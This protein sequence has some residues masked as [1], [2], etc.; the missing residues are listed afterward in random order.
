[1]LSSNEDERACPGAPGGLVTA[2]A[3]DIA[4]GLF[5]GRNSG[6]PVAYCGS[7]LAAIAGTAQFSDALSGLQGLTFATDGFTFGGTNNALGLNG[8]TAANTVADAATIEDAV[9]A[10]SPSLIG[11]FAATTPSMNTSRYDTTATLLANGIVLIAGGA[12]F[13]STTFE[14]TFL[15]STE[16]YNPATNSF[17]ASTPVMTTAR[18]GATATLLPNGKVL[19]ASGSAAGFLTSAELYDPVANSF[20]ATTNSMNIGRYFATATLLPNGKVLIA[21]GYGNAGVL[22]STE[23]YDPVS[24]TFATTTPSTSAGR[25]FATATLLPNGKVLIAGGYDASF[26]AQNT[27]DL[28]DPASNSFAASTPSMNSAR[29]QATATLLP[30]GKV[31]IAGGG[32]ALNS[33]E[34]Y[35]PVSNSFAASTPVMNVGRNLAV[36]A[37][38]PSGKVLIAGGGDG[39]ANTELYDPASNTFSASPPVMN[40]GRYETTATLL[41]SGE[42]L[43]AGGFTF[44]TSTSL[45]S[46]ELYNPRATPTPTP[47]A[48]PSPSPAPTPSPSPTP[49]ASAS[50]SPSPTASPSPSPTPTPLAALAPSSVSFGAEATGYTSSAKSVKL[51]NNGKGALTISGI[52]ATGKFAE[53]NTC[54]PSVAAGK[55]CTI[56]VTFSPATTGALSGSLAVSDNAAGS[57]QSATLKGSG[58]IPVGL[59]AT[60]LSFASTAAGDS[61]A[62]KNLT[63]TNNQPVAV[64]LSTPFAGTNPGDFV[65]SEAST[66]GTTVAANSKCVLALAFARRRSALAPRH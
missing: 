18:F 24:N 64:S 33:T 26:N 31:L 29:A 44:A 52:A 4:D 16:L 42:V 14:A 51:T 61:S 28:Y 37:L 9:A 66:C 39:F 49:A 47:T 35:D 30:N 54:G 58:V 13:N 32:N 5:D 65:I 43:I 1:M 10:S 3:S 2:L 15:N 55:N 7:S 46:T 11:A 21:G 57:P 45:A 59:S 25:Y 20:T 62:V 41:P 48:S 56:A 8:V 27:T 63:V 19:V 6:T 40:A 22:S 50:P 23:L 12:T 34:L 38:L 60:S 36:A 17:G 53:T